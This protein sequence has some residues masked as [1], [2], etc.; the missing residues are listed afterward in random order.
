MKRRSK[1][2]AAY[3]RTVYVPMVRRAVGDGRRPCPV[4]SEVCT[5]FV[6]GLHEVVT[7]G[8]AGGLE[9]AIRLGEVVPCCDRCNGWI[10]ENSLK[11]SKLEL[12]KH[13]WEA[14]IERSVD[15]EQR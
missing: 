11:A 2:R 5:R 8:R 14:D 3:M 7:R 1:K 6:E 15:R 4:R 10:S 12:I 13:I 9:A